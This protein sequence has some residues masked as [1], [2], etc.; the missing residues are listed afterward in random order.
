MCMYH[1]N[2]PDTDMNRKNMQDVNICDIYKYP[3][4]KHAKC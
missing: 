4:E 3:F 2:P 1:S